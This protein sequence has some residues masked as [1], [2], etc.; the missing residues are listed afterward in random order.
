MS[1]TTFDR[2]EVAQTLTE[3]QRWMYWELGSTIRN[4]FLSDHGF[5]P[6]EDRCQEKAL[7]ALHSVN[8][9]S[10]KAAKALLTVTRGW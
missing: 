1:T 3:K 5:T 10:I 2:Y 4:K 7:V 8:W 6:N 9:K